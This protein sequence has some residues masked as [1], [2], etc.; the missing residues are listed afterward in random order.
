MPRQRKQH[1]KQRPSRRKQYQATG[2]GEKYKP[3]FPMNIFQK[4]NWFWGVGLIAMVGGLIVGA[5]A[6]AAGDDGPRRIDTPDATSTIAPTGSPEGTPDASATPQRE[7]YSAAGQVLVPTSSYT[8]TISTEKGDIELEFFVEEAPNTIN[9]F[10][11]LAQEGFFD[12]QIFHR[13][14][15]GFVAQ[16][17]DPDGI[18]GNGFDG[19]G[20]ETADEPNEIRNE[21]G[22]MS[23]AK[24]GGAGT[25]GSQFFINLDD[26]PTLDYDNGPSD[27]FYPFARVTSGMDVVDSLE[28]GD[29]IESVT[30]VEAPDPN[31]PTPTATADPDATTPEDDAEATATPTE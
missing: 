2:S 4:S 7:Q 15:E 23:M 11:F 24:R 22:T 9:S 25:F 5:F 14:E 13:I 28:E 6:F 21:R 27:S 26:N 1:Q 10:L 8:G 18:N 30:F 19:P 16:A 31:A 17:G 3:G 12:G 20:Y 29:V